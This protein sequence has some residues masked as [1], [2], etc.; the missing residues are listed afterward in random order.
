MICVSIVEDDRDI[1]EGLAL[2]IGGTP[3]FVCSGAYRDCESAFA[4]IA[5][6]SPDVLLLDIELPGIS[7]VEGIRRFRRLLPAVDILMLTVHAEDRL[8]FDALC[9][10]AGGYLLKTTPPTRLLNAIKEVHNGGAPMSAYIARRVIQSFRKNA[11]SVDLTRRETEI[12]TQLCRGKSYKMIAAELNISRG[13]VHCHIKNIYKKLRVT[14][15]AQAVAK[16]L[17]EKL[18]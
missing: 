17:R 7:G 2:I 14:S 11:K 9:A 3:G 13:T 5:D 18:V 10:G 4:Q 12:L 8:V 1:R 6:H 15:N 16:A